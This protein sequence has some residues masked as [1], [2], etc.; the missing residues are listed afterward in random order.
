MRATPGRSGKSVLAHAA[1][2][3]TGRIA[4]LQ[5][6]VPPRN[7][8]LQGT[9]SWI[10][11]FLNR[12]SRPGN[13]WVPVERLGSEPKMQG[14]HSE[15]SAGAERKTGSL[16]AAVYTHDTSR[17]CHQDALGQQLPDELVSAGSE[18]RTKSDLRAP[19]R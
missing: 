16:I 12:D 17:E 13:A 14:A 3:A 6:Y 5:T 8:A 4:D 15:E 19:H 1:C 7:L 10:N 11:Y 9:S 2:T 18:R